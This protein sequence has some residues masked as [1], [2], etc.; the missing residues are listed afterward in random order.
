LLDGETKKEKSENVNPENQ[1]DAGR[2]SITPQKR[3]R[4]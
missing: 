3:D 2:M 1:R 4:Y